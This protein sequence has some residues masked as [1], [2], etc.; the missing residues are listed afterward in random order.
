MAQT[1]TSNAQEIC[2]Q[3]LVLILAGGQGSRLFELTE[4]RAKPGL[5]FGGNYRIIDF[6][7]S[8]CANSGL[9]HIGVVTQYKSQGLIH[10]LIQGWAK[11]N[12]EFGHSFELL[13][14]SQQYSTDWYLGTADALFQNIEFIRSV[15]AKY[16]LVL[17]G[18][19]I[20]KMD[21]RSMLTEHVDSQADL[22][23]ACI[24][25]PVSEAAGQFG[26]MGVDE[27][28]RVTSFVEKP[29]QPEGLADAPGYTLASM[30]NYVFN[31]DFLIEHLTR[32]SQTSDS[33]HDFG[34][35]VIPSLIAECHVQA[36]RFRDKNRDTVPY[37]RD[38]GTLDSYWLSNMA[39]LTSSPDF[40]LYDVKWPIWCE[41]PAMPPAKFVSGESGLVGTACDSLISNGC[42]IEGGRVIKSLLFPCSH[43]LEESLL[44]EC[45]LLPNSS[46]G[47]RARLRRV[48]VDRGCQIP[49]SLEAGLDHEHDRARGFR[50]SDGGIVL[51][52]Q[53]MLNKVAVQTVSD[54]HKKRSVDKVQAKSESILAPGSQ[55]QQDKSINQDV[56]SKHFL[57]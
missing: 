47:K 4:S 49:E 42:T 22:S 15:G 8:N 35:N 46:V 18:D 12:Q 20:Y 14:A 29:A 1:S 23:V 11:S 25:V 26:V 51:I 5:E 40:D 43:V 2:D 34:K 9:K 44:E 10:H 31:T 48:I 57:Q 32:D 54:S 52:T 27:T 53:K 13:P 56:D 33:E 3:T 6:P 21:Y 45:L 38:V 28:D 41:Q 37:W 24:E 17:S 55:S 36:H 39:L 19:H 7:L 30:G 16:V 50:V